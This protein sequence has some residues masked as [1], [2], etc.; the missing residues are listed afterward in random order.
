MPDLVIALDLIDAR[1]ILAELEHA[2]DRMNLRIVEG[3]E[4]DGERHS[5]IKR[6][7]E[8][9]RARVQRRERGEM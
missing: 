1:H 3:T 9:M 4:V 7:V 8:M 5:R 6:L 2:Y